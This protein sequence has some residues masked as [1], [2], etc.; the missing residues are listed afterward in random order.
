[1]KSHRHLHVECLEQRDLPSMM[2]PVSLANGILNIEVKPNRAHAVVVSSP[3]AG[4]VQVQLDGQPFTFNSPVTQINYQGGNRGDTFA[5]LTTTNGTINVGDGT[6]V[7]YSKAPG[8]TINAGNGRNVIQDQAGGSTITAGDGRN[9]IYGGPGDSISA[10]S[11]DNVIYDILGTNQISV[12][13]HNGTDYIFASASSNV[14][15]VQDNDYFAQFFAA[16][17]TAGSG[18]LVLDNGV[19][20][21]TANNAGDQ[22]ILTKVG[23]EYVANYNLNDGNGIQTQFFNTSDV[24]LVANFG[25]A[26]ND[27]FINNTRLPDVQYGA[28]G[29]NLL[30]GGRGPLDLEKA[31]GASGNSVALGRS[32]RY[33]DLNGSGTANAISTLIIDPNAHTNI[34]RTNNPNDQVIGFVDGQDFFVS[35]FMLKKKY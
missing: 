5:N 4:A 28:G 21:F 32:P 12:A 16:G 34:I 29:N 24:R 7:V 22:F 1:M 25:G 14:S 9:S 30:I 11:G 33:N 2:S 35:P 17:R 23:D 10:G 31:G 15:G 6:N 3:T 13:S 19:L 8:E 26:G 18:T 27:T 20:Y